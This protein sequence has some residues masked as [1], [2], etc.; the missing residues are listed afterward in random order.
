MSNTDLHCDENL[1]RLEVREAAV[2]GFDY[3]EVSDDQRTLDVVF[4]GKA[5][6]TFEK[7]NLLLSGGRRILDV[8]I[9]SVRVRRQADPTLDDALEVHVD[10]PGDFSTYTLQAVEADAQGRP[11]DQPM[12]GFDPR[13]DSVSFSFKAGCPTGIDC[14]TPEVCPPPE[15]VQP[16]INYLAKDYE[17]FRQLMRDRLALTMPAWTETHAPDLGIALVELLAYTGDYLSYY[18]DA[19]ATEAYLGTARERISV[20]RHARLVDYLMHDGC[21]ARAWVTIKTD[22]DQQ[23]DASDLFFVTPYPG[24]PGNHLLSTRDLVNVPGTAYETFQSL[25]TNHIVLYAAHSEIHFYTWGDCECC[26]AEGATSATLVDQWVPTTPPV[27][28]SG[29][30]PSSGISS[31]TASAGRSAIPRPAAEASLD[32]AAATPGSDGPPGTVRTL[33]LQV[34]DILIFEEVIGPK[35]GNPADADPTHRQAVRLTKVTQ[36]V[37][38]LYHPYGAQYGQPIVEVEWDVEDAL[39]F[40]LCI[41]TQ[42]PPPDCSCIENVSV[43]RGNVILVDNGGDTEEDLGTVPTNSVSPECPTC[44]RPASVQVLAGLYR[45]M[46]SGKPLT[47]L[48]PLTP[49]CSAAEMIAQDP[50]LALPALSLQ[51]IPAGPAGSGSNPDGGSSLQNPTAVSPLFTFGDIDDPTG[52]AG[53]LK[54]GGNPSSLY[55]LSQLS[56]ATRQLLSTW[57]GTSPIPGNLR[58]ALARD[59]TNLLET[60]SPIRDLLESGPDDREFVAEMDNDGYAHLRFGDGNLGRRPHAGMAFRAPCRVGNGTAG[61]VGAETITYMALRGETLS[62]VNLFPRNPLPATGGTDPEPIDDVK[63]FAPYAFR[64]ILERA[65]TANDYASIAGDNSRRLEARAA[66]EAADPG[67]CGTPFTSLQLAKATLRWTGSWY[68]ALVAPDPIGS[69]DP[70][71]E[72]ID[73]ISGYLEP[74]RRMGHDLLVN[75]PHYVPLTLSMR[76]CVL[77]DYQRAHVEAAALDVLGDRILPDGRKGFFHPDNL[78]FGEGIFVSMLLAVV[79]VIPGVQSVAVTELERFEFSEPAIDQPGEELPPDWVL[80][81]GPLEI[82]RL[83]NDPNFP[84]NG[85]LRLDLRGGR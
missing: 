3:V 4:L 16:D 1:R 71:E 64:S 35:T 58:A 53:S 5:P 61:N 74:Y 75:P 42:A 36:G 43:V 46:L 14:K 51:S 23:F 32:A 6:K 45:P 37:D 77:P 33:H 25:S 38:P 24:A 63:L 81:L 54:K 59:L 67:I 22:S 17:S 7:G 44:C 85:V 11:T 40:S 29:G 18:Q 78:T 73:E 30:S 8:N 13:Y 41:S 60:W 9:T 50:R 55:L 31:S 26:L 34:G 15:R 56:G 28:P 68:T 48:E 10:K 2:F 79:Q 66:M 12:K 21:N 52:L 72:L 83:D 80:H 69:E 76:I 57:D 84:E 65:I 27:A 49:V 20:R 47:F 82:A 62:G 70:G 19:V 39:T